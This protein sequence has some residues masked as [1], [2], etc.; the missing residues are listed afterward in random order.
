MV[1]DSIV[2]YLQARGIKQSFLCEKTGL[3]KQCVSQ[4][5]CGKRKLTL[6]E[7]MKI[8]DALCVPY[9]YF[10]TEYSYMSES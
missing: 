1:V 10:F 9:G 5:L 7:Y 4:S 8:C 2:R 3:S 6:E